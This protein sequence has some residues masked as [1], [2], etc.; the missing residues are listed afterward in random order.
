MWFHL[1]VAWATLSI[2]F[3][4][5]EIVLPHSLH[6]C[7][8]EH[9]E[10]DWVRRGLAGNSHVLHIQFSVSLRASLVLRKGISTKPCSGDGSVWVGVNDWQNVHLWRFKA[11]SSQDNVRSDKW[12]HKF[13]L[14]CWKWTFQEQ[15]W[16]VCWRWTQAKVYVIWTDSDPPPPHPPIL[17]LPQGKALR[18]NFVSQTLQ[19]WLFAQVFSLKLCLSLWTEYFFCIFV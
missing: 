7:T 16:T 8:G 5:Y 19:N 6:V 4:Y 17:L 10:W 15:M 9:R 18:G 2:L 14:V 13:I 3:R 11:L 1:A 12:L